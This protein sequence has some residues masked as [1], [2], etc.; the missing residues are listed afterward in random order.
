MTIPE[1]ARRELTEGPLSTV[2]ADARRFPSLVRS[3]PKA[4]M[5]L[6]LPRCRLRPCMDFTFVTI[7]P[8]A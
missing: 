7:T 8:W 5:S 6:G 2:T 4:A 3:A 1:N